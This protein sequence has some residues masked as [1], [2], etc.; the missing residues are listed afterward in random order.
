MVMLHGFTL[1]HRVMLGSMEPLF[2]KRKGWQRIYLDLPGMGK[3][4]ARPWVT[5]SDQMLDAILQ[6]IDATLPEQHF[7]VAGQSY[8]GYLGRGL[9]SR[10]P[11]MV[12]GLLLICPLVI[13]DRTRRTLPKPATLVRN[14]ALIKSLSTPEAREFESI[15]VVQNRP[16]WKRFAREILAGIRLAN[17]PFL[18]NLQ[19]RGYALSFNVDDLPTPFEKPTLILTGRQDSSVG[20]ADAWTLLD[21]YPR[22]TLAV[23]DRAGHDLQIEQEALFKALVSE[24]LTRLEEAPHSEN[25]EKGRSGALRSSSSS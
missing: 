20:Y 6:F 24:W 13:A 5:S 18:T 23:L 4:L 21:Q 8:G 2:T 1:D 10:R 14:P 16:H 15:A 22:A 11:D 19:A 9:V 3:T 7:V 25:R 17:E 12:D